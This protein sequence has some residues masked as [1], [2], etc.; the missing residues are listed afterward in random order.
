MN[1]IEKLLI[2]KRFLLKNINL[3]ISVYDS[4]YEQKLKDDEF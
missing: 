4:N 1:I 3:F 2:E